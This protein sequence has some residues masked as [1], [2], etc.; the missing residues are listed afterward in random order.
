MAIMGGVITF[1]PETG[2]NSLMNRENLNFS[3]ST[4]EEIML[5]FIDCDEKQTWT[6]LQPS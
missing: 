2:H 1:L 4:R 6:P 5:V 3:I